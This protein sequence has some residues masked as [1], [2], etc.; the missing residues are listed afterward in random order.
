MKT[1]AQYRED[2]K[3]LMKKAADIDAQCVADNRD[4]TEAEL[5]LKNEIL[6]TVDDLQK[7]VA[8]Q[9]RQERINAALEAPTGRPQS[10]PA[11]SRSVTVDARE[12]FSSFGEQMAAIMRAGCPGGSVDPRLNNFRAAASG[13]SESV[14]SDGGLR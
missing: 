10:Q 14:P 11:P 7:I 3:N 6:D 1:L 13:L 12:R 8:T 5:A 9:E 2:I 4:L